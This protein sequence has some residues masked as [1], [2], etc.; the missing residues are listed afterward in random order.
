[1]VTIR[2][3]FEQ[4]RRQMQEA[5]KPGTA[6]TKSLAAA[7]KTLD[8]LVDAVTLLEQRSA[9]RIGARYGVMLRLACP[10]P[11]DVYALERRARELH[12]ELWAGV[13]VGSGE[14]AREDGNG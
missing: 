1:M 11:E 3:L 7:N 14:A 13:F 8:E 12:P 2:G 9:D 4:L 5:G 10:T 6:G